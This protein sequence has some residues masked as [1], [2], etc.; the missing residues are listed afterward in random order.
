MEPVDEWPPPD[1]HCPG[2]AIITTS[3]R[4]GPWSWLTMEQV[5]AS[6][7]QPVVEGAMVAEA[8][9]MAGTG[10]LVAVFG[11]WVGM[12][13]VAV[14]VLEVWWMEACRSRP[15]EAAGTGCRTEAT[16]ALVE[17]RSETLLSEAAEAVVS[18]V[19]AAVAG[20]AD[21]EAGVETVET[22]VEAG[23]EE[24]EARAHK[25]EV[26]QIGGEETISAKE[27]SDLWDPPS[28]SRVCRPIK[29]DQREEVQRV[30]WCY[31]TDRTKHSR[32]YPLHTTEQS[33]SVLRW[34]GYASTLVA[35]TVL[36]NVHVLYSA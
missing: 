22:Q 15:A 19:G 14:V 10:R 28:H 36:E 17:A 33:P 31:S 32:M 2:A 27:E 11:T 23:G 30:S 34:P 3:P 26:G 29:A 5:R 16:A 1:T 6:V 25:V 9:T 12:E 18:G 13:D 8:A 21:M 7:R 4:L 24:A 20:G 35:G